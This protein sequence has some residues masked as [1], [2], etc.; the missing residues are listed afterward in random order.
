[1]LSQPFT[2]VR[3]AELSATEPPERRGMASHRLRLMAINRNGDRVEHTCF[4]GI[5]E[6]LRP[7]DLLVLNT[8][9]TLVCFS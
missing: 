7:G 8:S 4:N 3:T 6:F 5:G 2:F 9:H 1:M